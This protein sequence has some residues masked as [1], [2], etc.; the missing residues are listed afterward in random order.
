MRILIALFVYAYAADFVVQ[1]ASYAEE[2]ECSEYLCEYCQSTSA[3][4]VYADVFELPGFLMSSSVLLQNIVEE[5]KD[6]VQGTF[7][8]AVSEK[9]LCIEVSEI[10]SG[11][12]IPDMYNDL[13][14]LDLESSHRV[15]ESF[16]RNTGN[17]ILSRS[18]R[19]GKGAIWEEFRIIYSEVLSELTYINLKEIWELINRSKQLVK[20]FGTLD[21][22][23]GGEFI[24]SSSYIRTPYSDFVI[25]AY[26]YQEYL[27][28]IAQKYLCPVFTSPR[29]LSSVLLLTPQ[30]AEFHY[31][32]Q[33]GIFELI[34]AI[35]IAQVPA[36]S[37][38]PDLVSSEAAA[39]LQ[40]VEENSV[41]TLNIEGTTTQGYKFVMYLTEEDYQ[42]NLKIEQEMTLVDLE[43]ILEGF[44]VE[45]FPLV[46]VYE[47]STSLLERLYK[48]TLYVPLLKIKYLPEPEINLTSVGEIVEKGDCWVSGL[49]LRDNTV[50]KSAF[51]IENITDSAMT[52]LLGTTAEAGW[53]EWSTQSMSH[54]DIIY[55]FGIFFYS[56]TFSG[57]YFPNSFFLTSPSEQAFLPSLFD[58]DQFYKIAPVEPLNKAYY[59]GSLNMTYDFTDYL[60]FNFNLTQIDKFTSVLTGLSEEIWSSPFDMEGLY[61]SILLLEWQI[62]LE[63]IDDQSNL[64]ECYF[65][66]DTGQAC[67]PGT[68]ELIIDSE[69]LV[70][71]VLMLAMNPIDTN[72]VFKIIFKTDPTVLSECFEFMSTVH[73]E[74]RGDEKK[75]KSQGTLFQVPGKIFADILE[76]P[77]LMVVTLAPF[78]LAMGNIWV[79]N[80]TSDLQA[81]ILV[82][83]GYLHG[84]LTATVQFWDMKDEL[85]MDLDEN[86]LQFTI[87]GTPFLGIFNLTVEVEIQ[88]QVNIQNSTAI[89][90]SEI[91]QTDLDSLTSLV[92]S[93]FL[94]WVQKGMIALNISKNFADEADLSV[95]Q[96]N[97]TCNKLT[98]CRTPLVS[99]CIQYS[100]G[101]ECLSNSTNCESVSSTCISTTVYC[102]EE[103][104]TC[105]EWAKNMPN[106]C[107]NYETVCIASLEVCD[108]WDDQCNG[109]SQGICD[110]FSITGIDDCIQVAY[111][112]NED[113]FPDMEC[114][115]QCLYDNL[116]Y[117]EDLKRAEMYEEAYELTVAELQGFLDL[118][119]IEVLFVFSK[120]QMELALNETAIVN[121]D[122]PFGIT[123]EIYCLDTGELESFET[124]ILWN[125]FVQEIIAERVFIWAKSI[126]IIR[127]SGLLTEEL[128]EKAPLEVFLENID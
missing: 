44:Y 117:E 13:L 122:V 107:K 81:N 14:E 46:P 64:C 15:I 97:C 58:I 34:K 100:Y 9:Y 88:V 73:V 59:Q 116:L 23:G 1:E 115:E 40:I 65:E 26:S 82:E 31:D 125:F 52:S 6:Y 3:Y 60:I 92:Q 80:T 75:F 32:Y 57:I 106:T 66:C 8:V 103:V 39:H 101:V 56:G 102:L 83:P 49:I 2:V 20:Y 118:S 90:Y 53:V 55:T 63:I 51:L 76:S 25:N 114:E 123:A 35:F 72:T 18:E 104:T 17:I 38:A 21:L 61:V 110:S 124:E 68:C 98:R 70:D 62:E 119:E 30:A 69:Y 41:C 4:R 36:F 24:I 67:W 127:S 85:V 128:N 27:G 7:T 11:P 29:G 43:I 71:N 95:Q 33:M 16:T 94:Q 113:E 74:L 111:K 120:A 5:L 79:F 112:C 121:G 93:E 108:K 109:E 91:L 77:S 47:E 48:I 50:I 89:A 126:M 54:N 78:Y 105:I 96:P 12:A 19:A 42:V 37:W 84:N 10:V 86:L 99:Y 22:P 28:L 87:T 45:S